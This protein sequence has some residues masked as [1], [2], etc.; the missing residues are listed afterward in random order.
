MPKEIHPGQSAYISV[1]N[2]EVGL[3]GKL[4]PEKTKEDVYVL[5]IN[6]SKLLDKKV[7]KMK[8]VCGMKIV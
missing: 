3:I 6:L 8:I 7:G 4:H 2:D 5:E 1:N